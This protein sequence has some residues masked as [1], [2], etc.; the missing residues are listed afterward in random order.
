MNKSLEDALVEVINTTISA[1][2]FI[3]SE[4]PE[5]IRQ[6]LMWYGVK[7]GLLCAI[8][9]VFTTIS[10]GILFSTIQRWRSLSNDQVVGRNFTSFS[11]AAVGLPMSFSNFDWLQIWIAPRIWL[12]E[13]ASNLVRPVVG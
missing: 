2:D 10:L 4:L 12:I 13:Y 9:F 8:G 6:L 3:I 7:T 11:L 1:K 5:T